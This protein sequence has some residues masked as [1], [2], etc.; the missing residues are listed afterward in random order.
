MMIAVT[1]V[2]MT[3]VGLLAP[4]IMWLRS[5][6]IITIAVINFTFYYLYVRPVNIIKFNLVL[7]SILFPLVI[8]LTVINHTFIHHDLKVRHIILLPL[9]ILFSII[10]SSVLFT[11]ISKNKKDYFQD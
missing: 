3:L 4:K 6:L 8:L 11:A 10:I 5:L 1:Y 7:S 9:F 2:L